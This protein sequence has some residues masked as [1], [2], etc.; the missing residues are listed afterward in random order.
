MAEGKFVSYLRVST[1]KQGTSGLGLEA[2]RA[3]VD[4]Y[5]NGGRWSVI[6]E[7]VEV[8]SGKRADRP[9]L[10]EALALCRLHG[11]VLLVAKLDRL[12]RNAAFLFNLRD[13][14][15]KFIAADMPEANELTVGIMAVVAEG[16]RKAISKRT[17][18]ALAA[19]KIRLANLT[20]EERAERVAKGKALKLGAVRW[21]HLQA[22][23][24]DRGRVAGIATR[25]ARRRAGRPTLH[26]SSRAYRL[27]VSPRS[28][29]WHRLCSSVAF[30]R[31]AARRGGARC[32]CRGCW[33]GQSDC[34]RKPTAEIHTGLLMHQ[35]TGRR[36]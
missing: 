18:E 7:L 6:R 21:D 2:Q 14:G 32:R 8:E 16:E 17:T 9:K 4:S 22:G 24:A 19:A 28:L 36:F 23:A 27:K 20:D 12:S 25:R 1:A 33:H 13:A 5:L 29:L 15:V 35:L 31:H 3:A 26:R 10:A 30:Q 11:A 34:R